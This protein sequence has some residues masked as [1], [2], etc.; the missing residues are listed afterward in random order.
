LDGPRHKREVVDRVDIRLVGD[1]LLGEQSPHH[2]DAFLRT[3]DPFALVN[4]E[5]LELLIPP[6]DGDSQPEAAAGE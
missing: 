4:A 3:R 5:R 2:L 1:I 6:A